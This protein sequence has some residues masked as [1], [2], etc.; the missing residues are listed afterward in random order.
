MEDAVKKRVAILYTG[1]TIGM[2]PTPDGYAPEPGHLSKLMASIPDFSAPGAE[3]GR[4]SCRE[5]V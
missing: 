4:A 1:G 3:I 5:R 2:K